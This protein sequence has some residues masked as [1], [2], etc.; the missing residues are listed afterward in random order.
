[1][2]KLLDAIHDTI[3]PV[4][5]SNCCYHCRS[6]QFTKLLLPLPYNFLPV[7]CTEAA[8][9]EMRTTDFRAFFHLLIKLTPSVGSG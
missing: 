3:L 9:V 1:M 2:I 4:E 8:D 7:F 5:T 6:C